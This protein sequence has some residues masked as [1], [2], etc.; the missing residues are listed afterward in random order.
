MTFEEEIIERIA[1]LLWE[2]S[3]YVSAAEIKKMLQDKFDLEVSSNKV[4]SILEM[5]YLEGFLVVRKR[6]RRGKGLTRFYSFF[7]RER[8]KSDFHD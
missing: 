6:S 2:T 8:A 3:K 5:L 7:P 1:E 4:A